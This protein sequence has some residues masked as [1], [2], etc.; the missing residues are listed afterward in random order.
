MPLENGTDTCNCPKI[1]CERHGKCAECLAYHENH[2]KYPP[3]CKR[4]SRSKRI[5]DKR[6]NPLS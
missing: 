2:K 4:Q 1:N 3:Y 5:K 6:K